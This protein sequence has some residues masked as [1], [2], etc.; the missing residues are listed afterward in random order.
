VYTTLY[1]FMLDAEPKSEV[2]VI[3]PFLLVRLRF[4][5]SKER[6]LVLRRVRGVDGNQGI[7]DSSIRG[8]KLTNGEKEVSDRLIL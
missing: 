7:V 4:K 2:G 1:P 3:S 8:M 5:V 6:R